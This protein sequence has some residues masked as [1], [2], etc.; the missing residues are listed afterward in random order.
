MV[1]KPTLTNICEVGLYSPDRDKLAAFYQN[2]LGLAIVGRGRTKAD[3]VPVSVFLSTLPEEETHQI[4]IFARPENQLFAFRVETLADLQAAYQH[5]LEQGL[6]IKWAFN[7]GIS[8]AFY[9][10]DPAGNLIKIAWFTGLAYPQPH[11]HPIDLNQSEAV[12]RQDVADLVVQLKRAEGG[13]TEII[14]NEGIYRMEDDTS[15]P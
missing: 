2:A 4:V 15:W 12:L 6:A 8:L 7:H 3:G 14:D 5:I 1:A 13:N 9:F 11:S 10:A